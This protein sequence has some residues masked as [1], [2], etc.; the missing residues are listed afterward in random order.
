MSG[1]RCT[2]TP[3]SLACSITVPGCASAPTASAHRCPLPISPP[4][5]TPPPRRP[6]S[7]VPLSCSGPAS[8]VRGYGRFHDA[9]LPAAGYALTT[10]ARRRSELSRWSGRTGESGSGRGETAALPTSRRTK[11]PR[12]RRGRAGSGRSARSSRRPGCRRRARPALALHGPSPCRRSRPRTVRSARTANTASAGALTVAIALT[13]SFVIGAALRIGSSPHM[14]AGSLALSR[15][16]RRDEPRL[17][18]PRSTS[19]ARPWI[20]SRCPNRGSVTGAPR[21]PNDLH[22]RQR[23]RWS[24]RNADRDG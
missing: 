15:Y 4:P 9:H 23:A 13:V 19:L 8:T 20:P 17:I 1:R 6:M 2:T 14:V 12:S 10:S 3:R 16:G 7:F 21:V 5:T 11:R 18:G 24:R 22:T